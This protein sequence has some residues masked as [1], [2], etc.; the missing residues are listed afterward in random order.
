[1]SDSAIQWWRLAFVAALILVLAL[2][3]LLWLRNQQQPRE[4][5]PTCAAPPP[6]EALKLPPPR[7]ETP[8][9]LGSSPAITLQ[10]DG[11]KAE[12][13]VA[14]AP[15]KHTLR[16]EGPGA[17]P[18]S[19]DF[20][21]EAF[22]PA[23]FE[24][25]PNGR[26]LSLVYL[27]AVCASCKTNDQQQQLLPQE[28]ASAPFD[29]LETRA[30]EAL[31]TQDWAKAAGFLKQVQ[32]HEREQ[33]RFKRLA[34]NVLQ[35]SGAHA[36]AR[37]QLLGITGSPALDALLSRY[38]ELTAS[39]S[40]REHEHWLT[41]WNALTDIYQ[42]LLRLEDDA[43]QVLDGASA[44][45]AQASAAFARAN[46]EH[47]AEGERDACE[48]GEQVVLDLAQKLRA[49]HPTDCELQAKVSAAL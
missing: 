22:D 4:A 12:G 48:Q 19:V 15:G 34:Q 37:A 33:T 25:E 6:V 10:V 14:L 1:M 44:R 41:R 40:Q 3:G 5:R 7:F 47:S 39:E 32:P 29:E 27:G 9:L 31:Q 20:K 46:K 16:A 11:A 36:E 42:R 2:S 26:F 35:S 13:L 8:V 17:P 49:F 43:P 18:L 28:A 38:D 24:V 45:L 23:V 30:A 21:T